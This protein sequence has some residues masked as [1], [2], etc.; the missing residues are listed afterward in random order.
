MGNRIPGGA[1][2]CACVFAD[3]KQSDS[4]RFP[5]MERGDCELFHDLDR[6]AWRLRAGQKQWTYGH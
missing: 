4:E 6:N 1:D 5:H 2:D 3:R